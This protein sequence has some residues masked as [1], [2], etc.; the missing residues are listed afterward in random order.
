MLATFADIV[1]TSGACLLALPVVVLCAQMLGAWRGPGKPLALSSTRPTVAVLVPANNEEAGIGAL[2]AHASQQ[3]CAGDRILVVADN[4]SDD[5]ASIAARHGAEVLVRN[6]R[7][8]RGKGFALADGLRHLAAFAPE[9]VIFL[10]ADCRLSAGGVDSLARA[11][12]RSQ[13][14]VQCL[15]L[16]LAAPGQSRLAEFAWRVKNELRPAGFARLG[17]PCQLFG[18][19]MA[20]PWRCIE[21][22]QFATGHLTEDTFIGLELAMR[23]FAPRFARDVRVESI[24]PESSKGRRQQKRRWL[25]GHLALIGSHTPRL[26]GQ[27]LRRGDWAALALG[28]DLLVP[29]LVL[30]AGAYATMFFLCAA[31]RLAGQSSL[32]LFVTGMGGAGFLLSLVIAWILRGKD[33]IGV[34]EL[35]E[36]PSYLWSVVGHCAN[37]A[38]GNRAAWI[39]AERPRLG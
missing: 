33:L 37:F 5:T 20:I 21:S 6:D 3:L 28:V 15:Y 17:F 2:I 30:L 22:G 10:D 4:C 7:L 31:W 32:P 16:M 14:P 39:R 36:A 25:H 27:A 18:T 34:T 19:G 9:I 29:P 38:L 35:L 23:G 26:I 8:R 11:S 12:A 1:L 24:F 13:S